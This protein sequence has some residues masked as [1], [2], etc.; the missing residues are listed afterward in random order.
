[1]LESIWTY[2]TS[3]Q[4][5]TLLVDENDCFFPAKRTRLI[6]LD[7]VNGRQRWSAR[8]ENGHGWIAST[9]KF[10]FYLCQHSKL[11]AF[12]RSNGKEAWSRE[13]DTRINQRHCCG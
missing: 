8:V 1:M 12:D 7:V 5:N 9:K 10:V 6:A 4:V 3:Q 11:I 2:S 13:L